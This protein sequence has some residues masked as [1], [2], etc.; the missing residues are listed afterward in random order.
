M[1]S[2]FSPV[3]SALDSLAVAIETE[4]KQSYSA[5]T[6]AIREGEHEQATI[7]SE[8]ACGLTA[9][10]DKTLTLQRDWIALGEFEPRFCYVRNGCR[11][12][13]KDLYLVL[14]RFPSKSGKGK[15]GVI[16]QLRVAR[17]CGAFQ[18]RPRHDRRMVENRAAFSWSHTLIELFRRGPKGPF[19]KFALGLLATPTRPGYVSRHGASFL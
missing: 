8:R 4:I 13:R 2:S 19:W 12:G 3:A 9:L 7:A 18:V 5:R 6:K 15:D 17:A 10:R 11:R 1:P 14:T 16:P